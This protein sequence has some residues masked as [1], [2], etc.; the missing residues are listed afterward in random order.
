LVI[1]SSRSLKMREISFAQF[2]NFLRK[3]CLF[4]NF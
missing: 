1:V 4:F 3:V 2:G